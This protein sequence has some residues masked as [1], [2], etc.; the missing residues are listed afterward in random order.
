MEFPTELD[1]VTFP[2]ELL[3]R[4][5]TTY[6]RFLEQGFVVR[7]NGTPAKPIDFT[8]REGSNLKPVRLKYKDE[9]VP[10]V[11]VEI[12]AGMRSFPGGQEA[13]E[14]STSAERTAAT[15]NG[16]FVACNDRVVVAA[17]KSSK[18]GWGT[19]RGKTKIGIWHP[20]YNGFFGMVRLSSSDPKALPWAT[21]KRELDYESPLW[22]RALAEDDADYTGANSVLQSAKGSWRLMLYPLN[23]ASPCA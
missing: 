14:S 5:A 21:T 17:D 8:L 7:V 13:D 12:I 4:I 15:L 23:G 10:S 1:R 9:E 18:T 3:Q 2:S 6:G 20:Q 11:T 19:G 22:R 16:W